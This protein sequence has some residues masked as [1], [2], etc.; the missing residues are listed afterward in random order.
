MWT[1]AT[2]RA[3]RRSRAACAVATRRCGRTGNNAVTMSKH[4]KAVERAVARR[5]GGRRV[6]VTGRARGD[7]PDV[8]HPLLALEVK[9][10]KELPQWLKEAMAQAEAAARD[11]KLPVVVLHEAGSRHSEDLVVLRLAD[12]EELLQG[13]S[14]H[15]EGS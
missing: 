8:E 12:L 9:H 2:T 5:L 11:D 7:A 1:S 3:A 10:R 15:L 6:P 13:G 4:W 14:L